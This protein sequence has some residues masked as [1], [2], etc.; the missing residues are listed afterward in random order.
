MKIGERLKKLRTSLGLTQREFAERVYGNV[1]PSWIG[2]IERG[3]SYPSFQMLERI[4]KTFSAPLSY[5]F[6]DDDEDDD[7]LLS[8][9]LISSEVKDLVKD[10]KRQGL[11]KMTRGF[12]PRELELIVRFIKI[13]RRTTSQR[14]Q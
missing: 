3:K 4:A 2:K 7:L 11:L 13:L 14:N 8:L 6:Q 10:K 12:S 5:F 9:D 1:D